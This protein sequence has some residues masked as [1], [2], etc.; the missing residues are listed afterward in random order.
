[1]AEGAPLRVA[2]LAR[3]GDAREQLRRAIT[4]LGAELVV[5]VDPNDLPAGALAA[6][7]ATTVLVSVEPAV[8][9]ALDRLEDELLAP[10]LTVLFD[11]AATTSTLAGWDQARWARHLAAKLLGRDVLPPGTEPTAHDEAADHLEP[12]APVTPAALASAATM[13]DF[14]DEISA[15]ALDVPAASVPGEAGLEAAADPSRPAPAP[16]P[17]ATPPAP[18][19]DPE[20]LEL[21]L[22][23][24]EQAMGAAGV[25]PVEEDAID[26]TGLELVDDGIDAAGRIDAPRPVRAS[27]SLLEAREIRL[28]ADPAPDAGL[29][30]EELTLTEAELA[31]FGA[32]GDFGDAPAGAGASLG[33]FRREDPDAL[34]ADAPLELDEDLARLAAELDGNL[35]SL[36]FESE[37]VEPDDS[38]ADA[39]ALDAA[40]LQDDAR[41][42]AARAVVSSPSAGAFDGG[43]LS[44]AEEGDATAAAAPAPPARATFDFGA[45]AGLELSPLSDEPVAAPPPPAAAPP[46]EINLAHLSLSPLVDEA[47][48][49]AEAGGVLLV[50]S[51][52]GG[53]DAVRQL[54]RALPA[55]FPLAVLLRQALD[56]GRHDRFV[57]QLAKISR[58]PVALA[59][60][61]ET[62]PPRAVRVL[63]EGLAS[64]G[65]LLFPA[66]AG[67][68]ALID[69]ARARDGAVVVLSGADEAAIEP[70]KRAMAEGL[71]VL[72]QDP[73]SCFDG[74]AASA[75]RD[76]GAPALPAADLAARLDAF[77]PS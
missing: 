52:I 37:A 38:D 42:E 65:A 11:E 34:D 16:A 9:T 51:G 26:L 57:E 58:L 31:A 18:E 29:E 69:A 73:A 76:A 43:G 23:A 61:A 53:P 40:P 77:Y 35:E 56:G 44:L 32:L 36:S 74:K 72:V 48:E 49:P 41:P 62:P 13:S 15:S 6:A 45:L 21:D 50:L 64:A 14:A 60:S 8:E 47:G 24:L 70:L 59:E 46:P 4:D 7:G 3:P 68:A 5:E 33:A 66:D 54:L 75:L 20:A 71:R 17:W 67:P 10:G 30:V 12:G 2:L 27:L 55:N 28:D 63:P 25:A 22:A 1:M 19:G 39:F